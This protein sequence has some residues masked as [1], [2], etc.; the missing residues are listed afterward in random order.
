MTDGFALDYY[1][2]RCTERKLQHPEE[3]LKSQW[4]RPE[5]MYVYEELGYHKF[6]LTE[7]MKTTEKIAAT[8]QSYSERKYEGNLLSLLNSRM[9]EADFEMPNFSKNIKE[10]FA[11]SD[12]NETGL[13]P[14]VQL[15]GQHRQRESGGLSGGLPLEA[16]RPDGL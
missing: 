14:A 7:R 1:M 6:K 12:K 16:L 4:I 5:D 13:P 10:D 8:A 2:L 15:P 11:P 9:A 3:L